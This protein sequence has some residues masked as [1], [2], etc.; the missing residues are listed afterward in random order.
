MLRHESTIKFSELKI[1]FSS[2]DKTI[3][4]LFSELRS[5]KLSGKMFG[6]IDKISTQ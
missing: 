2:N 3:Q 4:A 6:A 5:L 1:F